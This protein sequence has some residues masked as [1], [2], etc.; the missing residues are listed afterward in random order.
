VV[1]AGFKLCAGGGKAFPP[2]GAANLRAAT[3]LQQACVGTVMAMSAGQARP[4]SR[5]S[6]SLAVVGVTWRCHSLPYGHLSVR[7]MAADEYR[8]HGHLDSDLFF[9]W[10]NTRGDVDRRSYP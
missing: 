9:G 5:R 1:P 8:P 4:A 2:E 7:Y 10:R 3:T 6:K